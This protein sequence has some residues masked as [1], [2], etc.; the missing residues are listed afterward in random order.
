MESAD[1]DTQDVRKAIEHAPNPNSLCIQKKTLPAN[2]YPSSAVKCYR[3]GGS[4]LA[5]ECRFRN[6]TCHFCHKRRHIVK[7][8]TMKSRVN[9]GTWRSE[10]KPKQTNWIKQD[11]I[12]HEEELEYMMFNVGSN[13]QKN[14]VLVEVAVDKAPLQMQVDTG[15]SVC[16]ISYSTYAALWENYLKFKIV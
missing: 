2:S 9:S 11:E 16:I 13:P 15:A 8:C 7:V 1:K 5:M 3:C 12:K 10:V 6:S 14:P 4:H